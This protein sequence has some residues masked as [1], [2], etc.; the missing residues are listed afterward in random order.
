MT[1]DPDHLEAL[2][3]TLNESRAAM[4]VAALKDGGIDAVAEGGLMA[5]FRGECYSE[6]KVMVR[7]RDLEAARAALA[8]YKEVMSEIDWDQVDVGEAE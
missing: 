4:I 2:T 6:V 3:S 8:E 1:S 7:S 5:N